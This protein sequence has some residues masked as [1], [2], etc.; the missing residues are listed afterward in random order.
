MSKIA[1]ASAFAGA[2]V[3]GEVAITWSD[4]GDAN[5]HGKIT[6]LVP[7][8]LTLG[9]TTT[10]TG[11]G[12]VDEQVTGGSFDASVTAGLVHDSWKGDLCSASTK[13]LPLGLGKIVFDGMKCP[14]SA[15]AASLSLG[16]TLSGA[17][18]ASMAKADIQLTATDSSSQKV[19]CVKLHT[20]KASSEQWEDF[21]VKYGKVYNGDEELRRQIFVENLEFIDATNANNNTFTLGVGPFADLTREEFNKAYLGF[22][23][24]N[25]A[26]SD[27]PYLGNHAAGDS[28]APASVDW[29]SKGAVT[30]VKNQ[31]QCGSCWSFST[32][33]SL[34]GAAFLSTGHLPS[35]SE[36]QFV[37]CA[38][39]PNQ[40]CNGGSMDAA[41]GWAKGQAI[42][43]EQSYP[44]HA[45][46]GSC[47]S[48]GCVVGLHKGQVT[49]HKDVALIPGL[50]PASIGSMKTAVAQQPVSVAIQAN[51]GV[52]QH[53]TGGVITSGC[54]SQLDHGVLVV[55]YEGNDW[56]V[57]NSWGATWGDNGYVRIQGSQCGILRE[58]SYPHVSASTV[59]V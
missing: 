7:T 47:S 57:K 20:Q 4:C 59:S 2:V 38:G 18:P 23:K 56:K 48:S 1:L 24:P 54:G 35:L 14:V 27:V 45:S 29:T 19:L 30:P 21:K 9:K 25:R 6:G 44:Y 26:T 55:G 51:Q 52:F 16:V 40:G 36:Q 28:A 34:E 43:T 49:G 10:V 53:Y 37:D 31:G 58:P 32:T 12:T 41:F 8:T 13:T 17:I 3:A 33:G 50:I 15:G 22:A 39:A 46:K 5:T 11:S 42:C